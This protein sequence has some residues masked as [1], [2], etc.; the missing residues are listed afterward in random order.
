ML[1]VGTVLFGFGFL[2]CLDIA[3]AYCTDCYQDVSAGKMAR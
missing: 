2:V 1:A 3:L